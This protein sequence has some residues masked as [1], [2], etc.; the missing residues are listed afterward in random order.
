MATGTT[1]EERSAK[2]IG[3]RAEYSLVSFVSWDDSLGWL[4]LMFPTIGRSV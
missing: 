2:Y 3:S 1:E 4:P